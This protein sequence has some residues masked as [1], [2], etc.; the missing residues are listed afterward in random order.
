MPGLGGGHR[1]TEIREMV[2]GGEWHSIN[3]GTEGGVV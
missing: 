3:G 1:V 2:D